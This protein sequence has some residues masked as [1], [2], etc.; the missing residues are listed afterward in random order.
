MVEGFEIKF[1][2]GIRNLRR[3]GNPMHPLA[4]KS[5]SQNPKL[6]HKNGEK[7]EGRRWGKLGFEVLSNGYIYRCRVCR[8]FRRGGRKFRRKL[9]Q[10][11][12]TLG[13]KFEETSGGGRKFRRFRRKFR[14]KLSC[15]P[16]GSYRKFE[17]TSYTCRK[18]RR[19]RR[20]FRQEQ[21]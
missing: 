1:G 17:E 18:F 14:W 19:L 9:K 20:K 4:L 6:P 10:R 12:R 16:R 7:S 2:R 15:R 11:P 5:H 3:M 8:K 13:R 21:K